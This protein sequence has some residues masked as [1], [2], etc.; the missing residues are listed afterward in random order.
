MRS[1]R[2]FA[3]VGVVFAIAVTFFLGNAFGFCVSDSAPSTFVCPGGGGGCLQSC[4]MWTP[5]FTVGPLIGLLVVLI[6]GFVLHPG[7]RRP[8]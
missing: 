7:S 8:A 1:W 4:Y 3:A 6:L 2:V 5:A